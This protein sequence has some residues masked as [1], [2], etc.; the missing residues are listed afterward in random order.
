[1]NLA[2]PYIDVGLYC[3]DR[4]AV[5]AFWQQ[6]VG[7]AFE[8]LLKLG[9]GAQQW[10]HD[11]SGSILK[12]NH[13]RDGLPDAVASGY[14]GIV[15]ADETVDEPV[16]MTDPEGNRVTLVQPGFEGI[17]QIAVEMAVADPAL[18]AT[19]MRR[20]L[21]CQEISSRHLKWGETSFYLSQKRDLEGHAANAESV[22]KGPGFRY[23]TVQV[24]DVDIEHEAV[25]RGGAV[26][27]MSP[28][29]LGET[30]RISFI[31]DPDGNWIELS[32][33]ASLTG[34]LPSD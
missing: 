30:A 19:F 25:V 27:A 23:I 13:Q 9:G 26:E 20:V 14:D 5:T 18:H 17:D 28:T 33:R 11:L 16:T 10:R 22:L 4:E 3:R 29:T 21:G 6:E 7:L 24:W 1:M 32:Q 2:K 34:P 8:S 15:V 12:I 31:K